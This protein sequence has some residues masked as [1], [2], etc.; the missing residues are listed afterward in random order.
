[1]T[2]LDRG[3]YAPQTDAPLAF[4]A[5]QP[6][7][8]RGGPAPLTLLVSAIILMAMVVGL[9]LF[10]RHGVRHAGQ[11]PELVGAPVAQ[12][13]S[14]PSSDASASDQAAGL[15]VYKAEATPPGEIQAPPPSF[16]SPP[17]QPAPLP[18][19]RPTPPPPA[20]IAPPPRPVV[21]APSAAHPTLAPK[22]V[23]IA[24]APPPPA[25]A[26]A[27]PPPDASY[28]AGSAFAS[29]APA[30]A[31]ATA[32]AV[33]TAKTDS[34]PKAL[35]AA[36]SK[37]EA[38][39]PN[40]SPETASTPTAANGPVMVQI[41]AFSTAAL[42]QKGWSDDAKAAP[43]AMTGKSRK[44]EAASKDGKT[45]YR[46]YVGGFA[47]RTEAASFCATLKAKDKACFIK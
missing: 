12:T 28:V 42:A 46:A 25:Q 39:I 22:P 13:K 19:A 9:L 30:P 17:E 44:V 18:A 6:R 26:A 36:K 16:E 35:G 11:A 38:K 45:F 20:I 1:M 23:V 14:A 8:G 5:R 41:G 40:V 34:A 32:K 4:D 43:A 7:G 24:K 29:H 3:A 15:Q 27:A 10:Y 21:S 33:T 37:V 2:E 47:T 31:K